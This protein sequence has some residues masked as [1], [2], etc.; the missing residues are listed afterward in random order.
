MQREEAVRTPTQ[1]R[2]VQF[3]LQ[4][5]PQTS[6]L[7]SLGI[8]VTGGDQRLN[9]AQQYPRWSKKEKAPVMLFIKTHGELSLAWK[10]ESDAGHS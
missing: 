1:I 8:D 3:H 4:R 6:S 10:T 5:A 7:T 9:Q 2:E